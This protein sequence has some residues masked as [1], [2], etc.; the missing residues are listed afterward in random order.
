MAGLQGRMYGSFFDAVHV[1]FVR[2]IME[3]LNYQESAGELPSFDPAISFGARK[4]ELEFPVPLNRSARRSLEGQKRRRNFV[5]P[6]S[7]HINFSGT[8]RTDAQQL[9]C[10]SHGEK[11]KATRHVAQTIFR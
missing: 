8:E 2:V 1:C 7:I 11:A 5:D 9:G 4:R 3:R 6:Q 10:R